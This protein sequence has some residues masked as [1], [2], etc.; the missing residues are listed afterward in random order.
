MKRVHYVMLG[1]ERRGAY[2]QYSISTV[3]GYYIGFF[4]P[5]QILGATKDADRIW[6]SS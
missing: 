5:E 6:M 3:P 2:R 4:K 1:M